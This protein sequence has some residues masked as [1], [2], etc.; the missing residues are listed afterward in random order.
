MAGVSFTGRLRFNTHMS[1]TLLVA[2]RALALSAHQRKRNVTLPFLVRSHTAW[3]CPVQDIPEL[4]VRVLN[5]CKRLS[6]HRIG[7]IILVADAEQKWEKRTCPSQPEA[8]VT[9]ELREGI[10]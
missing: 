2:T 9:L 3:V 7:T 8:D 1:P 5:S 10:R 6:T 4:G